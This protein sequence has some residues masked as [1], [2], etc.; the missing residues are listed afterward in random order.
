MTSNGAEARPGPGRGSFPTAR[1]YQA[2]AFAF[3]AFAIYGSLVPFEW[4]SVDLGTAWAQFGSTFRFSPTG[5]I[6]RSD[7]LANVLLFVPIGF[8]LAA[9]RL[10]DRS[11]WLPLIRNTLLILSISAA[12]SFAAEF[13]QLF[14]SDRFP[15]GLDILAQTVGTMLGMLAWGVTGQELTNWTRAALAAAP[16]DRLPRLVLVAS[17]AWV[18]VNLAPFDVTIDL[19][20]LA[21]RI[22]SGRISLTPFGHDLPGPSRA[23]DVLA[24]TVSAVPLG[25]L[26]VI[27]V[28]LRGRRAWPAAFLVGAA[29]VVAIEFVQIF[30][31]SHSADSGDA[32][33][34]AAGAAI[35]V[36]VGTRVLRGAG[37]T[38]PVTASA[39]P[40]RAAMALVVLW[41]FVLAA[42]HWQPFDFIVDY[43]AI[44]LKVDGISM[45]PFANYLRGSYLSAFNNLLTKLS[46]A[47]AFGFAASFVTRARKLAFLPMTVVW[48]LA[49]G[50]VF[51]VLEAGQFFLPTRSPDPTDVLVGVFGTFAGLQAGRW[52]K[53]VATEDPADSRREIG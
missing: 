8:S 31:K 53:A 16:H 19:G 9:V 52:V 28:Q 22:R 47:V 34:G 25:M 36:A 32:M 23:W 20:D 6:S 15:S 43:E 51:G 1:S 5:R 38:R 39:G 48:L 44:R 13:L 7:V 2:I 3:V 4:R 45:L 17:A 24:E 30:I 35:G 21:T 26:G 29:I 14:T 12:V 33:M 41:C 50:S 46:L 10:V 40:S 18:F 42:Y 27:L 11:G 49:A 37:H